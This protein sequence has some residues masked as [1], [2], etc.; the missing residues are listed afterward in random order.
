MPSLEGGTDGNGHIFFIVGPDAEQS[1]GLIQHLKSRGID[2][3]THYVALHSS[4]AGKKFGRVSGKMKVTND[5]SQRVV[6]L[7]LYYGMKEEE[8]DRVIQAIGEFFK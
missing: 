2:A 6:R 7:P 5:L 8:V 4:K 3:I 1:Q